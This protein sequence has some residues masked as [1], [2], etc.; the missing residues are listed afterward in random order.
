MTNKHIIHYLDYFI[1]SE[2]INFAVLIKGSWG[3]GKTYF[4]KKLIETWS[5][6]NVQEDEF[7]SLN[8]IYI[9]LNGLN[10]KKEIIEKLKEKIS[11]FLHSKGMKISKA[12]FKGFIKS[13]LKI[14]FDYDGDDKND[15]NINL[16]FDPI[17]IFKED[18]ENI[19]GR[20]IIIFDDILIA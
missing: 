9:S 11:P 3:S 4:I 2:N 20:R 18:N 10:S 14:D 5:T 6:P 1:K 15:G 17:S 19:K 13:T 7:I 16:N 8:P 12:I